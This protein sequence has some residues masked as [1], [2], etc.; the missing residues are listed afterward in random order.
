MSDIVHQNYSDNKK[1]LNIT[2]ILT[3]TF[4]VFKEF[5]SEKDYFLPFLTAFFFFPPFTI[6]ALEISPCLSMK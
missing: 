3:V 5:R 2:D 6:A 4:R 1:T